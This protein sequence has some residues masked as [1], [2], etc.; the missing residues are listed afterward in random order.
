MTDVLLAAAR[1]A[2]LLVYGA[3]GRLTKD[4]DLYRSEGDK[5]WNSLA[6]SNSSVYFESKG[7]SLYKERILRRERSQLFRIRWYGDL[8]PDGNDIVFLELKT[9]HAKWV[10]ESSIKQRVSI[11]EKDVKAFLSRT[12]NLGI[13]DA[14]RMIHSTCPK[15]HGKELEKSAD[16]LLAMHRL[17]K[18]HDLHPCIRT[19]YQV[20]AIAL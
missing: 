10:N 8:K 11:R 17:V 14:K 4:E 9:H 15:L 12:D 5:L 16:L 6:S 13:Q 1:E 20:R 2:P 19:R 18:E 3:S 7:M